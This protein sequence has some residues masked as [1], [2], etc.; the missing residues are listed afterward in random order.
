MSKK[1]IMVVDDEKE[2]RELFRD[3]LENQGYEVTVCE[4]GTDAIKCLEERP[5]FAAFV[6]IRM[7]GM[8]GVETLRLMKEVN[9]DTQVVMI[10]GYTRNESVDKALKLGCFVCMMKPFKLQDIMSVITILEAGLDELPL[11]A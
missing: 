10:T 3:V 7:P 4:N 1:H 8:D 5:V 9:P 11:A 2:I 6:D